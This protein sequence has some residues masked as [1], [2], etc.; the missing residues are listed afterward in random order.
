MKI[1]DPRN[2][3]ISK[4]HQIKFSS[5]FYKTS[6]DQAILYNNPLTHN[7]NIIKLRTN[8]SSIYKR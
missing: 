1:K 6:N 2:I 8:I 4:P 5:Q 3:V 7:I